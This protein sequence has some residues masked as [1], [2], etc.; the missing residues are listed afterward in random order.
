[1]GPLKSA[2]KELQDEFE[3]DLIV[4]GTHGASGIK[5][6]LIGSNTF[7]IIKMADCPVLSIPENASF[8][9]PENI[10]FS[11]DFAP[12]E[13]HNRLKPLTW[14]AQKYDATINILNVVKENNEHNLD[15]S[16]ES[17]KINDFLKDVKHHFYFVEN[18]KIEE[19]ITHTY[20]NNPSEILTMIIH[21][22]AFFEGLFHSSTTRKIALQAK[23]PLLTIH[24]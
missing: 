12:I 4:M 13:N 20:E 18:D 10:I 5:K 6:I 21:D 15:K 17:L 3:I 24:A 2:I 11:T 8:K 19:G 23:I 9:K 1:M 7:D 22:L 14:I 16:A